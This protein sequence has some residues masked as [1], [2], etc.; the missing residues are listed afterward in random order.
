MQQSKEA[1]G[2]LHSADIHIERSKR[3]SGIV[4]EFTYFAIVLYNV[5]VICT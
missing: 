5:I 1:M 2:G 4:D 3:Q